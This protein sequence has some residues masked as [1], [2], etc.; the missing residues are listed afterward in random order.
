MGEGFDARAFFA[1]DVLADDTEVGNA[2]LNIFR[3]VVVAE[4]KE[5]EVKILAGRVE[6]LLG[7]LELQ[8]ACP[9]EIDRFVRQSS[10]FLD[11]DLE[12]PVVGYH[13]YFTKIK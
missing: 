5:V 10:A 6:T 12:S 9:Q 8:S 1:H 4:R 7:E 2:V 3:D 13:S 11:G